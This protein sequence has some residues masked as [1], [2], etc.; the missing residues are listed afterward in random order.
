MLAFALTQLLLGTIAGA[1]WSATFFPSVALAVAA[2]VAA[3]TMD[4]AR[5]VV[6]GVLAAL[7]LLLEGLVLVIV[8]I[9]AGLG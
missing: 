6:Y 1:G 9:T 2:A 5:A 4:R 8:S 3:V 7:W